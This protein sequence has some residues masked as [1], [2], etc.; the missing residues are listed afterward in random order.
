LRTLSIQAEI[1]DER[2]MGAKRRFQRRAKLKQESTVEAGEHALPEEESL[3]EIEAS[4]AR[5]RQLME[6]VERRQLEPED[7]ALVRAIVEEQL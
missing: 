1:G 4:L 6:R 5:L 3:E 7:W 2:C